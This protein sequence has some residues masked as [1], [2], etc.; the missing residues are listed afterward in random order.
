MSSDFRKERQTEHWKVLFS[1]RSV[2]LQY[3]QR[4]AG[5]STALSHCKHEPSVLNWAQMTGVRESLWSLCFSQVKLKPLH[6]LSEGDPWAGARRSGLDPVWDDPDGRGVSGALHHHPDLLGAGHLLQLR[7]GLRTPVHHEL[8][9]GLAQIDGH[10]LG[11][12]TEQRVCWETRRRW[13]TVTNLPNA[14]ETKL[15]V[16]PLVTMFYNQL[17]VWDT[18]PW[19]KTG[20]AVIEFNQRVASVTESVLIDSCLYILGRVG[21]TSYV[22]VQSYELKS[23]T[24]LEY[25]I[26]NE[27]IKHRFH[28]NCLFLINLH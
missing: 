11:L 4:P 24:K 28:Q 20:D 26:K 13:V 2:A 5:V 22:S 6:V 21:I 18:Q 1:S 12:L 23:C 14:S 17:S 15:I 9:S 10:L 16:A 7:A 27:R 25:H 8:V 3:Q 19:S